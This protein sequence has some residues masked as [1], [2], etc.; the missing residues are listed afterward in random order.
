MVT[1]NSSGGAVVAR[2]DYAVHSVV[3]PVYVSLLSV[4][5]RESA[6]IIQ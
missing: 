3:T 2:V 6:Q 1:S 5:L 4:K